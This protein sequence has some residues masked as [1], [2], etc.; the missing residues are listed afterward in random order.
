MNSAKVFFYLI[1]IFTSCCVSCLSEE[2]KN[3]QVNEE[4]KKKM[5]LVD[6]NRIDAYPLFNDC[7]EMRATA[8][9]FYEQLHQLIDKKLKQDTIPIKLRKKDSIYAFITVSKTGLITYDSIYTT[10]ATI[11]KEVLHQLLKSRLNNFPVIQSA[12]KKSIPVASSYI[13]PIVFTPVDSLGY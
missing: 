5:E 2:Q 1:L 13:L 8:T 7:D 12:Q 11:D 10:A 4:V 3:A 6:M 9:C